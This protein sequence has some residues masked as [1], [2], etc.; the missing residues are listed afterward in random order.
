M[1]DVTNYPF[2]GTWHMIHDNWVGTLVLTVTDQ[3]V[4]RDI[5]PCV[6][7]FN[8][9]QGTYTPAAGGGPLAVRG[10]VGGRDPSVR[11][12]QPCP[13]SDHGI[14]FTIAFP[15]APPQPFKGYFFTQSG[16]AYLAGLT[17]WQGLPFGWFADKI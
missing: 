1:S 10:R 4:T 8:R 6:F 16:P 3:V 7:T 2:T 11:S 9:V 12:G 17:W 5:P 15:S 14:N 13:Q